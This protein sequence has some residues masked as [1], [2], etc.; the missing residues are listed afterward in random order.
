[1]GCKAGDIS[2]RVS[3][4]RIL[5]CLFSATARRECVLFTYW[6]NFVEAS[7]SPRIIS[8]RVLC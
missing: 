1:M 2:P 3:T 6:Q 8:L 5:G 7:H 4:E